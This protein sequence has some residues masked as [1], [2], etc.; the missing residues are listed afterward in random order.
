M[1]DTTE[2]LD[3]RTADELA[4]VESN[5]GALERLIEELEGRG[6]RSR[7][8]A[9]HVILVQYLGDVCG[10][11]LARIAPESLH[12]VQFDCYDP[13]CSTRFFQSGGNKGRIEI[14]VAEYVDYQYP[15]A[16]LNG[17]FVYKEEIRKRQ[18]CRTEIPCR[19]QS[20]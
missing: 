13:A 10:P 14:K 1:A 19:R 2:S 18:P 3:P 8:F 7:Q 4:R 9:A 11:H 12:F 20:V 5:H 6:R 16:R 15:C 17:R